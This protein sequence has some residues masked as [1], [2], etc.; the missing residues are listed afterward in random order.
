MKRK[1]ITSASLIFFIILAMSITAFVSSQVGQNQYTQEQIA[2]G[3]YLV[4][5]VSLCWECHT[6]FGP[7]GPDFSRLLAGGREFIPGALWTPNL[8]PDPDTGIGKWTDEQI[9]KAIRQGVGHYENGSNGE[10][11]FPIMPYYV[12]ANMTPEDTT[13][14]IAF[15][16]MGVKPVN[17]MVPMRA[18]YL[19]PSE[20][21]KLL[22]YS[23]LPGDNSD[24]GKYLTSA[25][26]VCIDC[27]TP[28]IQNQGPPNP[29]A[30][31]PS[32]YFAGGEDFDVNGITVYSE[33]ITSDK[34]TGIGKW[35]SQEIMTAIQKGIDPEGAPSC[36]PMD[37]FN[38][39]TDKDANDVVNFV[40]KLPPINH[41]VETC[42]TFF[43]SLAPRLNMISLPLMPFTPYTAR[44]FAEE[45][46]STIVIK[47]DDSRGQF[48]GF[49]TSA[50][51]D[52]FMIEGGKGYIVNV[53]SAKTVVFTGGAWTNEPA[54]AAPSK[55]D[56]DK[57]WAFVV[58]G[59]VADSDMMK[60]RD[61]GYTVKVKNL[62]TGANFAENVD[63]NGYFAAASADLNRRAIIEVNDNLE[64]VV[65]DSKGSIVS[66]PYIHSVILDEIQDAYMNVHLKLGSIIPSHSSLLQ[67]Y[68]NPF[69]PVTWIPYSLKDSSDFV[70]IKI[71]NSSGQLIRTLDLGRRDAGVYASQSKAAYW[72]GKN[73]VG[74][75]VASGTYFY[76]IKAGDFSAIRKM[77]VKK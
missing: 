22:D 20:P 40:Q 63:A 57:A 71:Y 46:S 60:V 21:A 17:N 50:P 28:R 77:L 42:K 68:P 55:T 18:P 66:G 49:T 36:P 26:G 5:N 76:S 45:L 58:N 75:E 13:S 44:S 48:V 34:D 14:I 29:A 19:I 6:P 72:D 61:G 56:S 47:Y 51:G 16:R 62:R 24:P 10:P 35:T 2:R 41:F 1:F 37:K 33:N 59:L 3:Q 30:L 9:A 15:L 4:M 12:F 38:G 39:L 27:H 67:N 25:A 69:N 65:L 11:L 43:M 32:L 23:S 54:S 74:E 70:N 53:P 7:N 73:E 52:G 31:D 64:I 8:T